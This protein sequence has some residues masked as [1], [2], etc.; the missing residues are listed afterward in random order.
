MK[1]DQ[2]NRPRDILEDVEPGKRV[3]KLL[4]RENGLLDN[5]P[6]GMKQDVEDIDIPDEPGPAIAGRT[7]VIGTIRRSREI[8]VLRDRVAKQIKN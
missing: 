1:F 3:R 5:G 6:Q 7:P 8:P 4:N 2:N